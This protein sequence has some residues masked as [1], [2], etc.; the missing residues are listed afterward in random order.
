LWNVFNI[1]STVAIKFRENRRGYLLIDN[2]QILATLDTQD[3][4]R[5]QTKQKT[6]HRKQKRR[7]TRDPPAP[8]GEPRCS[9]RLGV[10]VSCKSKTNFRA[11]RDNWIVIWLKQSNF[12]SN[13]GSLLRPDQEE[14]ET[15]GMYY[16]A[17]PVA[18]IYIALT[19]FISNYS[20]QSKYN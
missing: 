6:Q 9:K 12:I 10:S 4:A 2:L 8:G 15:T 3:T 18:L 7:T 5:R 11:L 1:Y 16:I 17:C 20:R 19:H 14:F 13:A